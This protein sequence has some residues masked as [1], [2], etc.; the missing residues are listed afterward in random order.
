M[1]RVENKLFITSIFLKRERKTSGMR[2]GVEIGRTSRLQPLAL[3]TVKG[4]HFGRSNTEDKQ[5]S[6]IVT[7]DHVSKSVATYN[8]L[9]SRR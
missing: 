4:F 3:R 8:S 6:E 7:T 9:R 1:L 2:K 5:R